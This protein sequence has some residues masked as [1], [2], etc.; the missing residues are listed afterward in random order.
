MESG[1]VWSRQCIASH[2]FAF[3]FAPHFHPALAKIG[4]LR[5]KLGVRTIFNL[6]GPLLN[7]AAAEYQLLGVGRADLLDRLAGAVARLG[8]RQAFLVCGKDGLDEVS[9]AGPTFVRRVHNGRVVSLE[10][11]PEDFGLKS[12]PLKDL[13]ADG[14]AESAAMVRRV[15]SGEDGPARWIT[16]ANAAA[17]SWP[18]SE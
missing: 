15:L 8:T 17:L 1:H 5:R 14:P 7:P 3:C 10:W 11:T 12:A 13:L 18:R 6:L 16:L 9:L 2:G 4:P